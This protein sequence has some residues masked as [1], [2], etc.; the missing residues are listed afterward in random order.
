VF[1]LYVQYVHRNTEPVFWH[2][3]L[4]GSTGISCS[5]SMPFLLFTQMLEMLEHA[6]DIGPDQITLVL[7]GK[8]TIPLIINDLLTKIND[9]LRLLRYNGQC[10]VISPCMP[11]NFY[12]PPLLPVQGVLE[13]L[14]NILLSCLHHFTTRYVVTVPYP[15]F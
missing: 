2:V 10:S 4:V 11:A 13:N 15:Y 5:D 8:T 12:S 9:H 1:L 6:A 7:K 14:M 3:S